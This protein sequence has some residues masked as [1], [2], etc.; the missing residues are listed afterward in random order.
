MKIFS[1]LI[2][3]LISVNMSAQSLSDN[4][5]KDIRVR[6]D[7][8]FVYIMD[9]DYPNMMEYAYPKIFT[10]TTKEQMIAVFDGLESMGIGLNVDDIRLNGVEGLIDKDDK[11][12]AIADYSVEIRVELLSETM[13]SPEV[14]ESLKSSFTVSYNAKNM[15]YDEETHMLSFNG[16]KYLL[17]VKDPD[18]DADN[19]YLLEY[20]ASN[21]MAAEML[22]D[23]DVLEKFKAKMKN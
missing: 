11:R 14:I 22:L 16:R 13:Q 5:E 19:W 4:D 10:L 21:P 7:E 23:S 12:F 18:Y 3:A 15:N 1:T 2:I 9:N 20:D 8:Y 6:I 17:A